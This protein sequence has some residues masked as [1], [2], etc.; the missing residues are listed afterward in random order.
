MTKVVVG[1]VRPLPH[2]GQGK[3]FVDE[4][5]NPVERVLCHCD[6]HFMCFAIILQR[7]L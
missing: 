3:E 5:K 1:H 2:F 4:R 7:Y 6:D